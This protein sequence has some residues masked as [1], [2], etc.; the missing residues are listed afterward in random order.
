MNLLLYHTHL[1]MNKDFF[2]KHFSFMYDF[3]KISLNIRCMQHD[4]DKHSSLVFFASLCLKLGT[5]T[6]DRWSITLHLVVIIL[7]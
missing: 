2:H 3:S 5:N 6:Q 7:T 4:A 1:C